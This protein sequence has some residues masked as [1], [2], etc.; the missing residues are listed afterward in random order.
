[1]N[2]YCY[3]IV[4]NAGHSWLVRGAMDESEPT[5][6]NSFVLPHLL[7]EGWEPVREA[8]MGGGTSQLAHVVILLEKKVKSKASRVPKAEK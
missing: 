6:K 1:M 3:V 5:E 4:N 8:P 7:Q 2:Q